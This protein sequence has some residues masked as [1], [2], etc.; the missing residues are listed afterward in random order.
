MS[1]GIPWSTDDDQRIRDLALQG[2]NLR[3]IAVQI[4]RS[5]SVI[6]RHAEKLKIAIASDRNGMMTV[7]RLA[8]LGMKTKG[9]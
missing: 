2:L 3:S 5:L 8:E 9:K 7:G 4:N 6:H 1:N